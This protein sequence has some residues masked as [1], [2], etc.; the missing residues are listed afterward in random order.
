MTSAPQGQGEG[1]GAARAVAD[2]GRPVAISEED[3]DAETGAPAGRFHNR[4]NPSASEMA[5]M[6]REVQDSLAA[7][8]GRLEGL[9]GAQGDSSVV[10]RRLALNVAEM[11]ESLARRMRSLEGLETALKPAAPAPGPT[12]ITGDRR[13]TARREN[14]LALSLGMAVALGLIVAGFW[15][16][17]RGEATRVPATKP[18]AAA[19]PHAAIIPPP[20]APPS[21]TASSS[22]GQKPAQPQP[23]HAPPSRPTYRQATPRAAPQ[24]PPTANQPTTGFRSY[25]PAAAAS[26][27]KPL[28]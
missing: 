20:S 26:A 4:L 18:M 23:S 5:E 12:A 7:L 9:E 13:P 19:L 14:V 16:F 21:A 2:D 15:V 25:G 27:P 28:S 8:D 24:A 10:T 1:L 22:A 3:F 6:L 17:G 11:G